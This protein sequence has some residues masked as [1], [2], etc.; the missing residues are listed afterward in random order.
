MSNEPM[1][2]VDPSSGLMEC[3]HCGSQ[4]FAQIQSAHDQRNGSGTTRYYRGAWQC[5]NPS[6][7]SKVGKSSNIQRQGAVAIS[8]AATLQGGRGSVNEQ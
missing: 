2:L 7:P 3:K 6:C 1:Q 8:R 4:H 5:P